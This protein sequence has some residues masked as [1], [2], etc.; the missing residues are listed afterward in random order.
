MPSE[1][2]EASIP[3]ARA[4]AREVVRVGAALARRGRMVRVALGIAAITVLGA[5]VLALKLAVHGEAAPLG[6]LCAMS[7]AALAWGA[8]VLI[9]FAASAQ[10]L[11]RDRTS[12]VR[13]LL[14]ARG[15]SSVAYIGGRVGGLALLLAIVVGGGTLIV[16]LAGILLASRI[17]AAG[18]VLQAT[19]A[20]L[21]Y[22]LAFAATLGPLAMAALGARSRAGGYVWLLV[23]LVLPEML[24]PW[25]GDALPA[26]WRE[27]A[28]VPTALGAFRGAL[29]PPGID[30]GRFV[31]AAFVLALVAAACVALVR[32]DM[33]RVDA[34][35]LG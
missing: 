22:S 32:R 1:P 29:M 35:D 13:A 12:G 30:W 6:E 24:M 8:G 19:I 26:P 16:G 2:A 31:R 5:L 25:T 18:R 17:G 10:A 9:A 20:S 15:A 14:R 23:L 33:I 27:V 4:R 21:A 7:A 34:E 11:R 28:S 3:R